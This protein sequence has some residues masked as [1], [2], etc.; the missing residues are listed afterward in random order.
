MSP[1]GRHCGLA[2]RCRFSI[3]PAGGHSNTKAE[4]ALSQRLSG[5]NLAPPKKQGRFFVDAGDG[6]ADIEN[7]FNFRGHHPWHQPNQ[8][9]L[10]KSRSSSGRLFCG[11][12]RGLFPR[13]QNST[14]PSINVPGFEVSPIRPLLPHL[15]PEVLCPLSEESGAGVRGDD[16]LI[17]L[18]RHKLRALAQQAPVDS[19]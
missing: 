18:P 13:Y 5:R 8:Q 7:R 10:Q 14:S 11:L 9:S 12:F 2:S 4:I 17:P 16:G 3:P 19:V 15:G 6:F 1:L